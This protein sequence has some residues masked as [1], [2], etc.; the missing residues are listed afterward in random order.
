MLAGVIIE[1]T[2]SKEGTLIE[3]LQRPMARSGRPLE[4]DASEG[5]FLISSDKFLDP[6]VYHP[7]KR[8]TVIGV[9]SGSSVRPLGELEYRYPVLSARELKLWEPSAGPWFSIGI[10]VYHGY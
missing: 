10:G 7:G 5:R 8:I 4:T 3:V 6:A 1:T 9:A 2:N